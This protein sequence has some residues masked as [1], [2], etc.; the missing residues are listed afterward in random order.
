MELA[1]FAPV[2]L[3]PVVDPE[4]GVARGLDFSDEDPRAERV[5]GAAREGVALSDDGGLGDEEIG[6]GVRFD[7]AFEV[8][9]GRPGFE[10][11]VEHRAFVGLEDEPGL[12]LEVRVLVGVRVVGARVDLDAEVLARVEV[13]DEE[14]EASCRGELGL[15]DELAPPLLERVPD[16]LAGEGAVGDFGV[17]AVPAAAGGAGGVEV[18]EFPGFSDGVGFGE[19]FAEL[20]ELA[21]A[22]DFG[23]EDGFED[24][25][26]GGGVCHAVL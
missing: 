19:G 25:G 10:P 12:G 16:G 2:F 18:G 4:G 22:P 1:P 20:F 26:V 3:G 21:P 24:E 11:F 13:F 9:L 6:D 17:C 5:D 7:R 23:F 14:G 15:V 8:V